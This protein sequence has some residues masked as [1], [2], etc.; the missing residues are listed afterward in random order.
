[1]Y[2][3]VCTL[4]AQGL[5]QHVIRWGKPALVHLLA[6]SIGPATWWVPEKQLLVSSWS[7]NLNPI[8][9][10]RY[11]VVFQ[12]PTPCSGKILLFLVFQFLYLEDL[13]QFIIY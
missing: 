6:L 2:A 5:V 7:L 3:H 8:L 4:N 9:L 10:P 13:P 1:M 11:A 12:L